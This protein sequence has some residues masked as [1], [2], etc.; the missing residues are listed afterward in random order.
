MHY[1]YDKTID[2]LWIYIQDGK[3]DDTIQVTPDLF[4][5]YDENKN[6]LRLEVLDAS[7]MLKEI[8]ERPP[9]QNA[10]R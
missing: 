3:Y 5:D 2:A 1:K 9:E 8:A 7:K 4:V 6:I 10:V